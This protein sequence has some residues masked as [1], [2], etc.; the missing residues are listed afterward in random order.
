[1]HTSTGTEQDD[2]GSLY[3]MVSWCLLT[4]LVVELLFLGVILVYLV[5]RMN[6]LEPPAKYPIEGKRL[7][8]K[9]FKTV[10]W[11]CDQEDADT[12]FASFLSGWF[13]GAK[14]PELKRGN[15]VQFMAWTMYAKEWS[16]TDAEERADI[17]DMVKVIEGKLGKKFKFGPGYN[18]DVT[19]IRHTLDP[20]VPFCHRP[21]ALYAVLGF[22][23]AVVRAGLNLWGFRRSLAP[24]GTFYYWFRKAPSSSDVAKGGNGGGGLPPIVLFHGV[25][26][27]LPFY[28]LALWKIC[29]KRTSVII[30]S[31]SIAMSLAL[32]RGHRPPSESQ[33]VES[34]EGI[35]GRHGL[36]TAA[37]FGHS[38][39]SISV[40]WMARRKS[41][42]VSQIVL[43]DP[44]CLLL[45]LPNVARSFLCPDT[46]RMPLLERVMLYIV[47][48]E[49]GI[50]HT[51][52]RHFWWYA[53]V[54]WPEDVKC[55]IVV[56]LAGLDKIV[57]TRQLRRYLLSHGDFA[58]TNIKSVDGL[59]NGGG[60]KNSTSAGRSSAG[61]VFAGRH[62]LGRPGGGFAL[63]NGNGRCKV[64]TCNVKGKCTGH[65]GGAGHVAA[66]CHS[67]R[68]GSRGGARPP[69]AKG[70]SS[71]I[72]SDVD[73]SGGSVAKRVEL[74]YWPDAGH[75]NVLGDPWALDELIAVATRQE[76][77]L[78][79]S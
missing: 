39:G 28:V 6:Q 19:S 21:L 74:V 8:H 47:T 42:L 68:G 27:G 45:F 1:M 44:V 78:S 52:R 60:A 46:T 54:M 65:G 53:N 58:R 50:S 32:L 30:E 55:P 73:K 62:G 23:R 2:D 29:R 56:G 24:C 3:G 48:A 17:M 69:T 72:G 67:I 77:A 64:Y 76:Q 14:V 71:G 13:V 70:D 43:L 75:G 35:M 4:W 25:G 7:M 38:F 26:T 49:K 22:C 59:A 33:L 40:A 18:P 61:G 10:D 37:F 57:P 5:P 79:V 20:V 63:M 31:P 16:V 34:V 36:K 41:H 66:P 51:L 15:M 9:I 12:T 11:L